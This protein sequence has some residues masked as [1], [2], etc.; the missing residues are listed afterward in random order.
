VVPNRL[1]FEI[2]GRARM[3]RGDGGFAQRKTSIALRDVSSVRRSLLNR[4]ANP[5]VIYRPASTAAQA[6]RKQP[7]VAAKKNTAL[8]T[9]GSKTISCPRPSHIGP[10]TPNNGS[11]T[12]ERRR[13]APPPPPR[14]RPR[15]KLAAQ[16]DT[17]GGVRSI[18]PHRPGTMRIKPAIHRPKEK[19]GAITHVQLRIGETI[20]QRSEPADIGNG[21]AA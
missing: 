6:L 9:K 21:D 20:R 18:E 4:E 10:K 11:D 14:R 16:T 2:V 7:K 3:L 5:R 15:E 12:E 13:I 17:D 19:V 1:F 8:M